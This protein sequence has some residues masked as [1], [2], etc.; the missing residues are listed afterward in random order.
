MKYHIDVHEFLLNKIK[1]G[2]RKVVIHLFDKNAQKID[3]GDVLDVHSATSGNNIEC[4]VK[5]IAI[6]DNFRDMIDVLTPQ[7]LGYD[8]EKEIM[9]R[10]NRMFP[11]NLQR[12]LNCVAFFIE[13][14]TDSSRHIGH[15]Q[16]EKFDKHNNKTVNL[17]PQMLGQNNKREKINKIFH[18]LFQRR[19]RDDAFFKE[20]E[21]KNS[22]RPTPRRI[23]R[24]EYIK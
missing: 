16:I 19:E 2:S 18:K 11:Q 1:N 21:T 17:S 9:V 15:G 4:I 20:Q 5:G 3:I 14:Q 12:S 10:I 8:N 13:L 22:I 6:F 23:E 24:D 7:T